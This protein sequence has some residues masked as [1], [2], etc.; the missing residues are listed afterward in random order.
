MLFLPF[1][2]GE[3][4]HR[5]DGLGL[6]LFIVQEIARAHGGEMQV[7]SDCDETR[8]KLSM[9]RTAPPAT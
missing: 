5:E 3:L 6:G 9:P 1:Q 8:F 4:S 2:R 7:F